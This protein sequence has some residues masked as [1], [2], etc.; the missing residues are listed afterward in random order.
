MGW[1]RV[2]MG[3]WR[4]MIEVVESDVVV[5]TDDGLVTIDVVG[6]IE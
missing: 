3:W 6:E 1:W 2:M 5:E 4:V